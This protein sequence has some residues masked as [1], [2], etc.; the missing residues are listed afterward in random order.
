MGEISELVSVIIPFYNCERFLREAIESVLAQS[1]KLWELLLVDDG[2]TDGGTEIAR[3]IAALQPDKIFYLE[4]AGHANCGVTRTR[5]LGV[6]QSRGEFLA[7]LDG[8][9]V[10][11]PRKLEVQVHHLREN[12]DAGLIFGPSEY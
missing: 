10:W 3:E 6:G 1:Y 2:S 9:D 5:N 12:P 4:H 11:L 7:F 8:D